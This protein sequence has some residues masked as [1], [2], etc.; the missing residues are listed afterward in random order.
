MFYVYAIESLKTERVYI[1]HTNDH[2]DRLKY[3]NSGYVKSTANDRPWR[4]IALEEVESR[5]E[6]R[7]LEKSLKNSRG[8]RLK[9]IK[10]NR[11]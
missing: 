5:P 10:I 11:I 4:I 9:W 1:G 6:A 3:H 7:W 2:N 8:K